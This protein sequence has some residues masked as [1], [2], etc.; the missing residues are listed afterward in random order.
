MDTLR[1]ILPHPS[2][3]GFGPPVDL[4]SARN[5]LFAC[6]H[7]SRHGHDRRLTINPQSILYMDESTRHGWI[8]RIRHQRLDGSSPHHG[9]IGW[10][11]HPS[12]LDWTDPPPIMDGLDGSSTLQDSIGRI[13]HPSWI[14]WTDDTV[15]S[16]RG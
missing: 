13:P 8:G 6:P 2:F 3:L 10:I 15:I 11:L 16:G 5:A 7:P 9:W 12:G 14:D 1:R 4:T